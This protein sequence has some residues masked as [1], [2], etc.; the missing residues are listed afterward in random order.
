MSDALVTPAAHP[1]PGRN[2]PPLTLDELTP[3]RAR[4]RTAP[5]RSSL[6]TR[7]NIPSPLKAQVSHDL[8]LALEDALSPLRQDNT[9]IIPSP[10]TAAGNLLITDDSG[11]LRPD[12]AD[13]TF[14]DEPEVSPAAQEPLTLSQLTP[15]PIRIRRSIS[16]LA[17]PISTHEDADLH[18]KSEPSCSATKPSSDDSNSCT[19]KGNMEL[20]GLRNGESPETNDQL[21]MLPVPATSPLALH[22]AS[23]SSEK[24]NQSLLYN[25]TV[26]TVDSADSAD[27]NVDASSEETRGVCGDV[28]TQVKAQA[29]TKHV[30]IEGGISKRPKP[31]LPPS[32]SARDLT[33][34]ERKTN[35]NS[36][37]VNGSRTT[38]RG[39]TEKRV[40]S[41][42]HPVMKGVTQDHT[43]PNNDI[44]PG[45][46]AAA[47]MSYS[48]KNTVA[49]RDHA[50]GRQAQTGSVTELTSQV[51]V[52][53][54]PRNP[55]VAEAVQPARTLY[56]ADED[57]AFDQDLCGAGTALS[58]APDCTNDLSSR[59]QAPLCEIS[60]SS[61]EENIRDPASSAVP[62]SPMRPSV[63]RRSSPG[64]GEEQPRKRGKDSSDADVS[65]A[66][67]R[68]AHAQ[69]ELTSQRRPNALQ[70]S[71]TKPVSVSSSRS[72]NAS[73]SS[74][75]RPKPLASSSTASISTRAT[76]SVRPAKGT[77]I[78]KANDQS[79][80]ARPT[81]HLTASRSRTIH[82][83]NLVDAASSTS[84]AASRSGDALGDGLPAGNAQRR[85]PQAAVSSAA[86]S[87]T[88][89]LGR[90]PLVD[91][92]THGGPP[93]PE[94][95]P[96][97]FTF[98]LGTSRTEAGK[99][100]GLARSKGLD[101]FKQSLKAS[102]LLPIP[103]YKRMHSAQEHELA[104]RREQIVP[105]VPLP[106]ELHTDT[107]AHDREQFEEGLRTRHREADRLAEERRRAQEAEEEKEIRELRRRA[108]P[109]A[110]EVPE[111][112]Q[113][114][115]KRVRR[116][117]PA[118]DVKAE[119]V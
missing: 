72:V 45:G 117:A 5:V 17:V 119:G 25:P 76:H 59:Q 44:A 91:K 37:G 34:V 42:S 65:T 32:R 56:S 47:L 64:P 35:A 90:K 93:K 113:H 51:P 80:N 49:T 86:S 61:V 53:E 10:S 95:P 108:V 20:V 11:F 70:S 60:P 101:E 12:T 106:L 52:P 50:V 98:S 100:E 43:A 27:M 6:K 9:F 38:E 22:G 81:R 69:S 26:G 85:F 94:K 96:F 40:P 115:P 13:A 14:T 71:R 58:T 82:D 99:A 118:D 102:G 15:A 7:P 39:A 30:A 114:A 78:A 19:P 105:V 107:R 111:W 104:A 1:P 3:R 77:A 68:Q 63:K 28:P 33:K 116:D 54:V 16:P 57:R 21:S 87:V 89:R 2:Q 92:P 4:F 67:P 29:R 66:A 62:P 109:K 24:S 18:L 74:R 112:Y 8:S 79:L 103:D 73:S 88:T 36:S 46:L 55:I 41:T 83:Q 31:K 48:A 23:G 75:G 84:V 110:H 97:E